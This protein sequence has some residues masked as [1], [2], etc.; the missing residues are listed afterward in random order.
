MATL[1]TDKDPARAGAML[2]AARLLVPGTLVEEAALR[3][4]IFL[5]ADIA[6][7]DKFTALSRQYI[8]RFRGSVF[9]SNFKGRLTSFA[10]R[11]AVAG[12]V[13]PLGQA[14]PV[15]AELPQAERRSLYLTLSRDAVLAGRPDAARYAA[16]RA[17]GPR[18]R[19][20]PRPNGPGS[21]RRRPAPPPTP[22]RRRAPPWR[23]SMAPA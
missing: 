6:T 23:G 20:R 17:G 12:D 5:V 3:R 4:Q 2:D 16:A 11:L 14:R 21:T 10:V 19:C 8:R 18:A 9:A 7:L 22:P 13:A 15:F 1:L